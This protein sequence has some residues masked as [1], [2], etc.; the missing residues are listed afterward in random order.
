MLS[1]LSRKEWIGYSA[2]GIGLIGLVALYVLEFKHFNRLL[3]AKRLAL[4]AF[5]VGAIIGSSIGYRI[6]RDFH[7]LTEKIQMIVFF[8]VLVTLFMPL[9]SSLSNRLLPLSSELMEVEFL[10][11]K[12]FY[13]DRFGLI[14]GEKPP[15]AGYHSILYFNGDMHDFSTK[16]AKFEGLERGDKTSIRL[17]T[18]L[19][20]FKLV[21]LSD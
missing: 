8:G 5:A 20:G 13:A 1:Q 21:E 3:E 15:P 9:F 4:W 10:E 14:E 19:W 16:Q 11:E 18:G 17:I 2:L 12:P 7:D 6:A